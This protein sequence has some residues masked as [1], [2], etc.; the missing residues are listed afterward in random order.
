MT[1]LRDGNVATSDAGGLL[2]EMLQCRGTLGAAVDR[3]GRPT[4]HHFTKPSQQRWDDFEPLSLVIVAQ[5][6]DASTVVSGDRLVAEVNYAVVGAGSPLDCQIVR[7][8]SD[9]PVLCLVLPVDPRLVRSVVTSVR[10]LGMTFPERVLRGR[11][12]SASVVDLEM[13][14]AI[15]RLVRSLHSPSDRHVLAPLL[16]QEIVYR[17]LQGPQGR[18][19]VQLAAHQ[20]TA[21]PVGAALA[22]IEAHLAEPLSVEAL[23]ARACLS[24]SGFSRIFRDTT[25]RGPYQYVKEARLDRARQL[26]DDRCTV[27]GAAR[28]VG[29]VSVSNFIKAFRHRFGVTP[30]QY[31]SAHPFRRAC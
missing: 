26:L 25:G 9:N 1:T 22:Y 20:A 14:A 28:Q 23:A 3:W 16:L 30:G 18:R 27:A 8:S 29:Y 5:S 15:S 24:P 10:G 12:P 21:H 13:S 19:L 11:P 2:A 17:A 31:A 4:I 6:Q 7:A